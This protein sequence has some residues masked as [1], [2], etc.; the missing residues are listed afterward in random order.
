MRER[1]LAII[2]SVLFV[3][4]VAQVTP[5]GTYIEPL[6]SAIMVGPPD[7][8]PP[9]PYMDIRPLPPVVL[10]PERHVYYYDNLYYYYWGGLWY[11]GKRDR[12]PWHKLPQK[13]YPRDYRRYPDR[14]KYERD[15]DYDRNRDYERDRDY[16]R[17]RE[18]RPPRDINIPG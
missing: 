12:G 3:G 2:L 7:I 6:S 15:R 18:R 4:C 5:E 1:L 13:Y 14:Y 8:E 9:P 16:D 11:Y 10:V 17:D